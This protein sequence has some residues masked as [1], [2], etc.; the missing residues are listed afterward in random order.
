MAGGQR[1]SPAAL[2]AGK[3]RY[4]WY[5]RLDGPQG[6]SGRV[7]K[8]SPAPNESLYRLHCPSPPAVSAGQYQKA[9]SCKPILWLVKILGRLWPT[10]ED[11][12]R[13]DLKEVVWE[14]VDWF[15]PARDRDNWRGFVETVVNQWLP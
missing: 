2:P 10:W 12:I 1:H 14:G 11:N 3:T 6:R 5:R 4:S 13:M 8:I 9:Q 15:D 7:R